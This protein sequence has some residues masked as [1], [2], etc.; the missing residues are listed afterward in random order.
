MHAAL[1][2]KSYK[3]KRGGAP[4]KYPI[5]TLSTHLLKLAEAPYLAILRLWRLETPCLVARG[6]WGSPR[7]ALTHF[8]IRPTTT[9]GWNFLV[10]TNMFQM[11]ISGQ[12]S[13]WAKYP[14]VSENPENSPPASYA[15]AFDWRMR[16]TE[17]FLPSSVLVALR[18]F[19]GWT[20][21]ECIIRNGPRYKRCLRV[22]L[23]WHRGGGKFWNSKWMDFGGLETKME[24]DWVG[25]P[26]KVTYLAEPIN[27]LDLIALAA[28]KTAIS[29][30]F[31]EWV[32]PRC[33]QR[34]CL[35]K[36]FDYLWLH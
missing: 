27:R 14:T 13:K 18:F 19:M 6:A 28:S 21:V 9:F 3:L 15:A 8:T 16:S 1:Y 31:L 22:L 30:K 5:A 23:T 34:W 7:Y 24:W 2:L 12:M 26:A 33:S 25:H 17:E 36:R 32:S 29:L 35:W 20:D 11:W 4:C 10:N